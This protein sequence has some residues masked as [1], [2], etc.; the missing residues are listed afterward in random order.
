MFPA[1]QVVYQTL[2]CLFSQQRLLQFNSRNENS[3]SCLFSVFSEIFIP[4]LLYTNYYLGIRTLK[5]GRGQQICEYFSK[6]WQRYW[7]KETREAHWRINYLGAEV[8]NC[9]ILLNLNIKCILLSPEPGFIL[10]GFPDIFSLVIYTWK[11]YLASVFDWCISLRSN[12]KYVPWIS[13]LPE[14]KWSSYLN[15]LRM[16]LPNSDMWVHAVSFSLSYV[17][18]QALCL[19]RFSPK[20]QLS[21]SRGSPLLSQIPAAV[22]IYLQWC[23]WKF[24]SVLERVGLDSEKWFHVGTEIKTFLHP[25]SVEFKLL[26]PW[27]SPRRDYIGCSG[28][29]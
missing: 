20:C 1:F 13:H 17:E 28:V 7:Y 16:F 8:L 29:E 26:G 6:N 5:L 25:S 19:K 27:V 2:H 10:S 11:E 9:F 14:H 24:F 21:G 18:I 23:F 4:V 22:W 15:H 3:M 12:H